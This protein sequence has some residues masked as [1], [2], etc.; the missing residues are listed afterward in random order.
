MKIQVIIYKMLEDIGSSR[1]ASDSHAETE[2]QSIDYPAEEEEVNGRLL[3][4]Q[5]IKSKRAK[6][7]MKLFGLATPDGILLEFIIYQGKLR[8]SLIQPE[9]EDWLFRERISP[10][11]IDSYL[12][13]GML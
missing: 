1:S 2:I 9:G 8:T 5:Y 13:K 4:K 12:N 7:G 3:F 10:T 6:F 11:L